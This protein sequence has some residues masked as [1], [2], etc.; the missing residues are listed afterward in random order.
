MITDI[1]SSP[2]LKYPLTK[3]EKNKIN[4]VWEFIDAFKGNT[5]NTTDYRINLIEIIRKKYDTKEFYELETIATK[6]FWNLRWLLFPLWIFPDMTINEY[7]QFVANKYENYIAIPN[8][9]LL[10]EYDSY[11]NYYN[12][13]C[14]T[15]ATK[16]LERNYQ[17]SS[18]NKLIIVDKD[19][20]IIYSKEA[21]GSSDVYA[22]NYFNLLTLTILFERMLYEQIMRQ[23][24]LVRSMNIHIPEAYYQMDYGF[25]NLNTMVFDFGNKEHKLN[26]IKKM[27]YS[28]HNDS[29][30][31]KLIT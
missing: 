11:T 29:Y 28:K 4:N 7:I 30:W 27:F 18:I 3:D 13:Q 17:R 20:N 19:N 8:S 5:L 21:E 23:P 9:L 25:P 26:R 24:Y 12:M 31:F 14:R 10:V 15:N 22:R 16:T 1:Y 6:M 2:L